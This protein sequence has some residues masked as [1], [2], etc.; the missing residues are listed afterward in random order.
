MSVPEDPAVGLCARC[1]HA[2]RVATPR[3]LFWLCERSRTDPGYA[4]YPRLPMLSCPGFEPGT[5]EGP[6]PG[7]DEH[8]KK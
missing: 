6:E 8:P 4:R 2:R 5:P 1:R 3:S 7:D